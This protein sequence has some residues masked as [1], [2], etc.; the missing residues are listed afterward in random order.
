VESTGWVM[1]R[2]GMFKTLDLPKTGMAVTIDIG[3][4]EGA[5]PSLHPTNKQ[6]VGHRLALWA[7]TRFYGKPGVPSGPLYRSMT[8]KG[9]A[10]I[11]HF[12]NTG[13]GM[14]AKGDKPTGF[15]IAGADKKFVWANAKIVGETVVVSSPKVKD[16]V[17]VRYGWAPNPTC[18]LYN[19]EGVPASPFR[20]DSWPVELDPNRR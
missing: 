10:I 7:L 15:A 20:T 17:A 11:L 16:P 12:D 2:E 8:R 5:E 1:V 6:D 4:T 19:T 13:S 14:I 3:G 9:D 18:N